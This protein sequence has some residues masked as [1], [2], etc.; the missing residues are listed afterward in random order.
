MFSQLYY[1]VKAGIVKRE[2]YPWHR[3]RAWNWN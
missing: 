1:S 2:T 3:Q